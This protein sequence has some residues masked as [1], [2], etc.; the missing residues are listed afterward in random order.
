MNDEAAGRTLKTDDA[1]ERYMRMAL[2]AARQAGRRGE[3]PIGAALV[4]RGEVLTLRG[5]ERESRN[6]PTAHAEIL[7]LRDASTL[8]G[9]WRVLDATLYVTVEPC[10]MCAGAILLARLDRL[11]YGAADAKGGAVG[12][13]VNV[14]EL[15]GFNHRTEVTSGVLA[16]ESR[17]LLREFFGERR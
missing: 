9:G 16:E 7:A 15:S 2:D 12:S 5:N 17:A 6:D 8:L 14:L 1:D 13:V 3:V 11:V 10:P 4:R